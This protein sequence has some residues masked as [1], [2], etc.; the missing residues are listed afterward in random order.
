MEFVKSTVPLPILKEE[1]WD[2]WKEYVFLM[3]I[4]RGLMGVVDGTEGKPGAGE[5]L[6][7]RRAKWVRKDAIAR[8]IILSGLSSVD[9][10]RCV[11]LASSRLMWLDVKAK[12]ENRAKQLVSKL[13]TE[14]EQLHQLETESL[15]SFVDRVTMSESRL[16]LALG[17][18]YVFKASQ[19]IHRIL[20]GIKD[21]LDGSRMQ[22]ASAKLV[23]VK[24]VVDLLLR[25]EE[26]ANQNDTINKL[27]GFR[28]SRGA[29]TSASVVAVANNK[30]P[31]QPTVRRPVCAGCGGGHWAAQCT[32]ERVRSMY[33]NNVFNRQVNPLPPQLE[34]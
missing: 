29:S 1:D 7:E 10:K 4:A 30:K 9:K 5:E 15:Q 6:A 17:D 19:T 2:E 23:E 31:A 20:G 18:N 3:L 26:Q 16:A 8:E 32:S 28:V 13:L 27:R 34:D 14:H 22:V 12:V 24:D 11:K 33:E 25:V 21:S